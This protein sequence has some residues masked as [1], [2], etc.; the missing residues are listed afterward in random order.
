MIDTTCLECGEVTSATQGSLKYYNLP[1][2]VSECG[3]M[4]TNIRGPLHKFC[5]DKW[6]RPLKYAELAHELESRWYEEAMR[7]IFKEFGGKEG[8]KP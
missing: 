6:N 7:R 8:N 5:F 2:P 4:I 3:P 1:V